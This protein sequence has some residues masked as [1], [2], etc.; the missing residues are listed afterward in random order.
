MRE[1]GEEEKE[2][3]REEE[4]ERERETGNITNAFIS[5]C[6][7]PSLQHREKD[8]TMGDEKMQREGKVEK[9]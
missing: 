9:K 1:T 6:F 3:V 7:R 4:R 2:G 5:P 8:K